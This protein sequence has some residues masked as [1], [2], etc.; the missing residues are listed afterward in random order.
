M[1]PNKYQM[2]IY[3]SDED[4]AYLVEVPELP[5]CMADGKTRQEALANAET[6][7]QEWLETAH[8]LGRSVPTPQGRLLTITETAERL[9]LSIAMV[10]RYCADG[11]LPAK[12]IGRDWVIQRRDV[13]YFAATPRHSGRPS[14]QYTIPPQSTHQV[15]EKNK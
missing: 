11:K 6:I 5:G 15:A 13:E 14:L 8:D 9:G 3:W 2:I 10:R 1:K 12:K 4:R 7:I